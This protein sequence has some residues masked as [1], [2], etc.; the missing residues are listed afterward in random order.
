MQDGE[1][2][3]RG[4]GDFEKTDARGHAATLGGERGA[5]NSRMRV[6]ETTYL[7]T[8]ATALKMALVQ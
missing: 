1:R 5:C 6:S 8:A 2:E 7:P 4:A 3:Q